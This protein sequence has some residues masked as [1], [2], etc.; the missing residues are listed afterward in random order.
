MINRAQIKENAKQAL[1]PR[2]GLAIVVSLI[3][4]ILAGGSG[5]LGGG[6]GS[7]NGFRI[8]YSNPSDNGSNGDVSGYPFADL[9]DFFTNNV[10]VSTMIIT[11]IAILIFFAAVSALMYNIFVAGPVTVGN[12]RYYLMNRL[13]YGDIGTLFSVFKP[14]YLN[15]VKGVLIKGIYIFLWSLLFFIPGIIKIFEYSMVEYILAENPNLNAHEALN[16]S[17]RMTDGKKAEI[18]VF[19]LSFL[20]WALLAGLTCGIGVI[21]LRPYI[22]ASWAELYATLREEAILKGTVDYEEFCPGSAF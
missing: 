20:G 11:I 19:Q 14:G 18:F 5:G 17:S 8:I 16:L 9:K 1:K 22:E 7:F 3:T 4:F 13:G 10:G 6:L 21:F 2:F 12:S 15:I